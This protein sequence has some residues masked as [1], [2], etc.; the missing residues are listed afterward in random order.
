MDLFSTAQGSSC[1]MRHKAQLGCILGSARSSS[2]A[3]T[4]KCLFQLHDAGAA[5]AGV[6]GSLLEGS[7]LETKSKQKYKCDIWRLSQFLEHPQ[8]AFMGDFPSE[9]GSLSEK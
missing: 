6:P 5:S 7:L 2:R 1:P 3:S 9:R 4:A 8:R